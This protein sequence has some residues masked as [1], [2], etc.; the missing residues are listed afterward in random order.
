MEDMVLDQEQEEDKTHVIE[1]HVIR[2][3]CEMREQQ[4]ELITQI[5]H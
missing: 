3:T 5:H 4:V 1:T 2:F